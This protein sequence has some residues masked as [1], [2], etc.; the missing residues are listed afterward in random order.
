MTCDD[1][2]HKVAT[3]MYVGKRWDCLD[4]GQTMECIGVGDHKEVEQ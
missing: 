1:H 2:R 3:T 4:C